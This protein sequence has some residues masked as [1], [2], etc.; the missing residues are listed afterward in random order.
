TRPTRPGAAGSGAGRRA[1]SAERLSRRRELRVPLDTASV[2]YGPAVD[3]SQMQ[4]DQEYVDTG[5]NMCRAVYRVP[6]SHGL[7]GISQVSKQKRAALFLTTAAMTVVVDA[8]ARQ[9]GR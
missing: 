4:P 9:Q 8:M 2:K 3:I 1:Q 5:N 7:L 6:E